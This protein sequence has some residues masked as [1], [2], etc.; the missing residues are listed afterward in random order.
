MGVVLNVKHILS[1][2]TWHMCAAEQTL[3]QEID[4]HFKSGKSK[5]GQ[6]KNSLC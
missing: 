1:G 6:M 5:P 4:V 3:L 2:D